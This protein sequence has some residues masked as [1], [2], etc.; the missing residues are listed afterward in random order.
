[1]IIH[2]LVQILNSPVHSN[3]KA[4][5]CVPKL[6]IRILCTS[7]A[8]KQQVIQIHSDYWIWMVPFV[9]CWDK[10]NKEIFNWSLD[11]HP[12]NLRFWQVKVQPGQTF[13]RLGISAE[14]NWKIVAEYGTTYFIMLPNNAM[15]KDF[16]ISFVFPFLRNNFIMCYVLTQMPCRIVNMS[17]LHHYSGYVLI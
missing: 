4:I 5:A 16:V 15:Q 17:H 10:H 12:V 14:Q 13:C 6:V 1:M 8:Y 9:S 2:I 11:N 3:V 7:L